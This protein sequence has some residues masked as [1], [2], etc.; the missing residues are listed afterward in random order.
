[1]SDTIHL[2]FE[3][4]TGRAISIPGRKHLAAL[5]AGHVQEAGEWQQAMCL[6]AHL[7]FPRL[8]FVSGNGQ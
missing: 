3:V 6:I 5:A 7:R 1:M 4:G 8:H 2:G